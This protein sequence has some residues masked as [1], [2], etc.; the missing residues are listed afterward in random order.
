MSVQRA[1]FNVPMS[2][3]LSLLLAFLSGALGASILWGFQSLTRQSQP[4][5]ATLD[6]RALMDEEIARVA[7]SNL[8]PKQAAEQVKQYGAHLSK[9]IERVAQEQNLMIL[10]AQVVMVG[11]KAGER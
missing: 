5:I 8:T 6:V 10:P 11:G 9:A 1:T 2:A 3:S 4:N 7:K